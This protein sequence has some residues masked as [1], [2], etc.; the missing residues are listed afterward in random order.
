MTEPTHESLDATMP[1]GGV[2]T[3]FHPPAE[4]DESERVKRAAMVGTKGW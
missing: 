1:E 2:M 4:S 3:F